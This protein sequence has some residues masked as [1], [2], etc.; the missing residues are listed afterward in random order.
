VLAGY[1]DLNQ[2]LFQQESLKINQQDIQW[3]VLPEQVEAEPSVN[4]WQKRQRDGALN[5]VPKDFYPSVW[6]VM[7][8]CKG[9]VIGDKLERRNR[10]DSEPILAEMTPGEKNFALRVEHLLN[11]IQAPE[12]RQVN[13]EA[14]IEVA[15]IAEQNPD[16]QIEEYIVLDVLIG[17][18]VRLAWLDRHPQDA[19]R[20]DEYK[21]TAWRAFYETSPYDCAVYVSKALRFLTELSQTT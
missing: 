9:L 10:L 3:N 17:H 14:L 21:A 19:V 2:T 7:Q 18:A 8:H 1:A 13:I 5:R 6:R 12:Y 15:A 4:W 16:L 11:K 20:Y